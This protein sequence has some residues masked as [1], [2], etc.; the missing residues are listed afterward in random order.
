[1][2]SGRHDEDPRKR[3]NDGTK[4]ANGRQ[5]YG[6][7]GDGTEDSA[8]ADPEE[9]PLSL[10]GKI[11]K[12]FRTPSVSH[13]LIIALLGSAGRLLPFHP[14]ESSMFK[15]ESLALLYGIQVVD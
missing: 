3:K 7:I 9:K 15:A 2:S 11:A 6:T 1:M 13:V 8:Q 5:S 12:W 14:S 10:R 4:K